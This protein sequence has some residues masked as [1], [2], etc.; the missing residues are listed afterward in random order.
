MTTAAKHPKQTV[1]VVFGGRSAEHKVSIVS[2]RT[3]ATALRTVGYGVLPL[4][5]AQDG[6]WVDPVAGA[7]ALD[8]ETDVLAPV[9]RAIQRTLR[10]LVDAEID[11]V[12]PIVHGTWGEDGTL[13]GLCEMLDLPYVGTGVA[14]SAVCMDKV[15]AKQVFAAAGLDVVDGETVTRRGWADDREGVLDRC[16]RLGAPLFVK[17]S[18]GGSSVGVRRVADLDDPA[19]GLAAAIDHALYFD[20]RLVVER[21]VDGRELECAVLGHGRLEASGVGEIVPGQDFYDY[22]DK[23]LEDG[24]ELIHAADLAPEVET[25]V[26]RRSVV[27]ME[28]VGGSGMARVDF[29]LE[30]DVPYLNE[31]N[32]LPGFTA[33]SMYPKLWERAGLAPSALVERLVEAAIARHADRQR[34]DRGIKAWIAALEDGLS[35]QD[36]YRVDLAEIVAKHIGETER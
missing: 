34:L 33:I 4:G 5:I 32:T 15:M 27:A 17:P 7:R 14:S 20:D 35:G 8:G 3:V 11:V 31:I 9:G 22:A 10:H 13:Q 2:A 30:G 6:C 23:Y 29:L 12:F 28:A 1:G 36:L 19:E 16:R 25:E 26:R 18:V 21:G 24:A